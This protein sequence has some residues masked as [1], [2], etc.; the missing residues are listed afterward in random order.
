MHR[1]TYTVIP[2]EAGRRFFFPL[3]CCKVVGLRS[4]ES[5]FVFRDAE[6]S[7]RNSN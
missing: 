7:A 2:S 6:I 4:E 1:A 5:L 3:C